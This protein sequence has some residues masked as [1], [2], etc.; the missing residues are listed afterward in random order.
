MSTAEID[1]EKII[2][3]QNIDYTETTESILK[4]N[5]NHMAL[6]EIA[7]E[8]QEEIATNVNYSQNSF[9]NIRE[10]YDEL[11]EFALQKAGQA[12]AE[13]QEKHRRGEIEVLS[14]IIKTPGAEEPYHIP[15]QEELYTI[16]LSS[17]I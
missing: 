11:E 16:E 3:A 14:R 1:Y 2:E 5:K 7:E 8:L 17:H 9:E 13:L 6:D 4:R 15:E 10:E 12:V